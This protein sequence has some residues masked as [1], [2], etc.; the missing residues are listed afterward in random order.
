LGLVRH[1]VG[2]AGVPAVHS[3]WHRRPA[4]WGRREGW[5]KFVRAIDPVF[6]GRDR[7]PSV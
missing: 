7:I 2:F 1:L 4:V 6:Y 3:S 5:G